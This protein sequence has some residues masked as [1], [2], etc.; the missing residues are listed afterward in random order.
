M[1]HEQWNLKIV[2]DARVP[3]GVLVLLDPVTK[4]PIMIGVLGPTGDVH[5]AANMDELR[6]IIQRLGAESE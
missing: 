4:Y 6:E 1:T 3:R 2:A 5:V